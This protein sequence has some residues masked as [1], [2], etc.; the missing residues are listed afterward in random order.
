MNLL[1]SH[2]GFVPEVEAPGATVFVY[3]IL[4][5][6]FKLCIPFFDTQEGDVGNRFLGVIR[7]LGDD[8]S[9]ST[10]ATGGNDVV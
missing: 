6:K 4:H 10:H 8:S 7:Y 3:E 2:S 5:E 9:T 1:P